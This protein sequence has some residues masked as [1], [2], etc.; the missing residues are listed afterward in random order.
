MLLQ[1]PSPLFPFECRAA[2]S[3]GARVVIVIG[4]LVLR[5]RK[6]EFSVKV[7]PTPGPS[8]LGQPVRMLPRLGR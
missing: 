2:L 4:L 8:Y 7:I 3:S 1:G 5:P 6:M